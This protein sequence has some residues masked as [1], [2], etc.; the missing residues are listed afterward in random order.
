M[1]GRSSKHFSTHS[2]KDYYLEVGY[3]LRIPVTNN[4]LWNSL[5]MAYNR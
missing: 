3:K 2:T 4:Y 1:V 5:I